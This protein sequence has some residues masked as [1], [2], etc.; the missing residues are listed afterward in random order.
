MPKTI[1]LYLQKQLPMNLW[2]TE[3]KSLQDVVLYNYLEG[4]QNYCLPFPSV[5]KKIKYRS[6][7]S[8]YYFYFIL[9]LNLKV[10]FP[11]RLYVQAVRK[12]ALIL[13]QYLVGV[14]FS[15]YIFKGYLQVVITLEYKGW[16]RLIVSPDKWIR[17]LKKLFILKYT[18]ITTC[19]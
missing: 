6:L 10:F 1:N 18:I 13:R 19:T 12:S 8:F 2:A 11:K 16:T 4:V 14:N 7:I 15:S 3:F 5:E 17:L 9:K